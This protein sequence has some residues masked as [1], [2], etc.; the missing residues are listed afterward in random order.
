[1]K[2]LGAVNFRGSVNFELFL[3]L[4]C[5]FAWFCLFSW[6]LLACAVFLLLEDLL[7][8]FW[9]FGSSI[10]AS[11]GLGFKLQTLRF[12]CQWTHQGED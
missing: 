2:V 5:H 8:L 4:L 1:L 9:L 10:C 11:W 12:C 7:E 3:A 6:H